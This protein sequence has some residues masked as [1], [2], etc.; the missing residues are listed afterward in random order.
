V[1]VSG[2]GKKTSGGWLTL[3]FWAVLLW[4]AWVVLSLAFAYWLPL[5]LVG[6][7]GVIGWLAYREGGW[8]QVGKAWG[9]Y[10]FVGASLV[11]FPIR[12]GDLRKEGQARAALESKQERQK[13]A[14]QARQEQLR[15]AEAE[16]VR[17]F[18][19]TFESNATATGYKV[20]SKATGESQE[21]SLDSLELRRGEYT[22]V[23]QA[24]GFKPGRSAFTVN[25]DAT[26]K[27]KLEELPREVT[28]PLPK[29]TTQSSRDVYFS[30]C[31]EAREAG[32]APMREG[33]LG[34]RLGLD[35]D[36]DGIACE[37][38]P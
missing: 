25:T 11:A 16:R 20:F 15:L 37:R 14:E 32:A 35:G 38:R 8:T 23:A 36:R 9:V 19:V 21:V 3:L 4:L 27:V 2:R 1:L 24:E 29:P 26:I 5:L 28:S 22:V 10:V 13:E 34:Y 7:A 17:E 18:T 6:I 12:A 31:R 33:Q 30:S